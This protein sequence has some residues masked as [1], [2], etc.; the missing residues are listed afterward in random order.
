MRQSLQGAAFSQ[1][2]NIP[3]ELC[4]LNLI[5]VLNRVITYLDHSFLP[6]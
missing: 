5:L 6:Y 3:L 1:M 4:L 2:I